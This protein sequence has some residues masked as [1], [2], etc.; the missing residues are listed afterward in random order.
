MRLTTKSARDNAIE[1]ILLDAKT[2]S[3]KEVR[4][5]GLTKTIELEARSLVRH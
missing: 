2:R 5:Y 3:E 1:T 4:S